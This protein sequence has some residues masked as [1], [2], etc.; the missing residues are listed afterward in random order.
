M[1]DIAD[2]VMKNCP[3]D[4]IQA[5]EFVQRGNEGVVTVASFCTGMGTDVMVALALQ[6][7]WRRMFDHSGKKIVLQFHHTAMVEKC[8]HIRKMLMQ[9]FKDVR[10]CFGDVN[11]M[12]KKKAWCYIS[13]EASARFFSFLDQPKRRL[14]L[15]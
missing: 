7:A 2:W 13:K 3:K 12:N 11:L 9:K 4:T 10:A 8:P 15:T 1:H 5:L 14:Y 6:D